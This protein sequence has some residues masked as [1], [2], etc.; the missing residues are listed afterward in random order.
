MHQRAESIFH[1]LCVPR[2]EIEIEIEIDAGDDQK[3]EAEA[4]AA[5]AVAEGVT[6][7]HQAKGGISHPGGEEGQA[8]EK[9]TGFEDRLAFHLATKN[10]LCTRS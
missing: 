5:V 7:N 8:I 1:H 6:T 10:L 4:V 3:S 9:E 2:A